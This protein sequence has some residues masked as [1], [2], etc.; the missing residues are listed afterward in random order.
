MQKSMPRIQISLNVS[1][2][3]MRKA[4]AIVSTGVQNTHGLLAPPLDRAK[5]GDVSLPNDL[6]ITHYSEKSALD[7]DNTGTAVDGASKVSLIPLDVLR[8]RHKV[9]YLIAD[10]A[11]ERKLAYGTY[12][13]NKSPGRKHM[14][15]MDPNEQPA[16]PSP[17]NVLDITVYN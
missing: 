6:H 8:G 4:A 12:E 3:Q 16:L 7:S 17:P 2:P 5:L 1:P 11:P 13:S 9:K 14:F 10:L 15:L